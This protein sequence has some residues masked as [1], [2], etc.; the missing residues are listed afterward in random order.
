MK[1]NRRSF[2]KAALGCAAVCVPGVL[3]R[4]KLELLRPT[5]RENLDAW[6]N[7]KISSDV[8]MCGWYKPGIWA[9]PKGTT[10]VSKG[11]IDPKLLEGSLIVFE[12]DSV[13]HLKFEHGQWKEDPSSKRS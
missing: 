12:S 5:A 10:D 7:P 2:L 8:T 3:P 6:D 13:V 9:L 4:K 1:R 11:T